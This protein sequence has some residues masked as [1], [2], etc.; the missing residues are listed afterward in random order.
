MRTSFR[1]PEYT[2]PSAYTFRFT[3]RTGMP[4]TRTGRTSDSCRRFTRAAMT[5]KKKARVTTGPA[6][7]GVGRFMEAM[8]MATTE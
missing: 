1:D 5:S 8:A 4:L 7:S 2:L 6:G 3:G